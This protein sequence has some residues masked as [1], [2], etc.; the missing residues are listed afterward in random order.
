MRR[1]SVRVWLLWA[2]GTAVV[3]ALSFAVADPGLVV[4]AL[5][6]EL[7]ALIVLSSIALLR[8]S[9]PGLVVSGCAAALA[10]SA[11]RRERPRRPE[12]VPVGVERSHLDGP[13]APAQRDRRFEP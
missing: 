11:R 3:L 5:D 2:V 13:V 12:H 8:I 7:I 4:L 1:H 10:R 6:P 9:A